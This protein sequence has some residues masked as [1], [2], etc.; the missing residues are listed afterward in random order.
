MDD[1]EIGKYASGGI[2]ERGTLFIPYP[3]KCSELMV[4]V[5]GGVNISEES[6]KQLKNALQ[7]AYQKW[8]KNPPDDWSWLR[9]L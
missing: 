3:D 2:P 4:G 9:E 1:K 7:E 6:R 8:L 5:N